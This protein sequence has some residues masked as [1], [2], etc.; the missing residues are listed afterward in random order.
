MWEPV[1]TGGS[2]P[3]LTGPAGEDITRPVFAHRQPGLAEQAFD[4]GARLEVGCREQDPRHHR[5]RVFGDQRQLI[6]LLLQ[7]ADVDLRRIHLSYRS[8][9]RFTSL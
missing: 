1:A 5:G 6:N 4:M 3:F 2:A 7:L 9:A 8:G